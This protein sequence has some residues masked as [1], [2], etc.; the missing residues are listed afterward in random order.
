MT[1]IVAHRKYRQ[2]AADSLAV[3]QGIETLCVKLFRVKGDLIGCAGSFAAGMEFIEWYKDKRQKKPDTQSDFVALV[4]TKNAELH[5]YESNCV[6]MLVAEEYY[7][8][9][10]GAAIAFAIMDRGG[11]PHDAV[12]AAIRRDS[13]TGGAIQVE[14][15]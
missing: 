15:V 13:G 9:G 1:T 11:T 8:I 12:E 10:T 5:Q 2:M 3:D 4:L 7:S 14:S 6:R